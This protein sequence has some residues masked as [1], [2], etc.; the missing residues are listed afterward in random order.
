MNTGITLES[1]YSTIPLLLRHPLT[2]LILTAVLSG[3]VAPRISGR[4]QDRAKAQ[5]I[6]ARLVED[7]AVAMET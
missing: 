3:I 5:E 2:L 1:L 6:K 7:I 4:W